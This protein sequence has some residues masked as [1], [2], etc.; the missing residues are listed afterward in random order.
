M[1]ALTEGKIPETEAAL[2]HTVRFVDLEFDN[3]EH[4]TD[5]A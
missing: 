3:S 4:L 2:F 5:L 1:S